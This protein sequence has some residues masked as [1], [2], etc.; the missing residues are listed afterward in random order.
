MSRRVKKY[1]EQHFSEPVTVRKIARELGV[2]ESSLSHRYRLESGET[3]FDTL[4]RIRTEQSLPLLQNGRGLKDIA[5][6]TGF[7]NEFY[8]SRLISDQTITSEFFGTNP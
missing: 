2:S 4:L 3:L 8:Y 5:E 6:E 7:S 1:L